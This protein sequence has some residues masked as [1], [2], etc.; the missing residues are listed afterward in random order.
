MASELDLPKNVVAI[1]ADCPFSS[2]EEIIAKECKKNGIPSKIGM[3]FIKLGA[4]LFGDLRLSGGAEYAVKNSKVPILIIH[5]ED[6]R[7]VPCDMSRKIKA[8]NP[9]AVT[10]RTFP[11]AAHGTSYVLYTD[12][13]GKETADFLEKCGI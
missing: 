2:P 8:A 5:G 3:P 7:F 13:Y 9:N 6:D 12:E 10:L 1:I 4:L 11:G